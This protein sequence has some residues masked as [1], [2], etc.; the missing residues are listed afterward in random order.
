MHFQKLRFSP[1]FLVFKNGSTPHENEL[2]FPFWTLII[3][4]CSNANISTMKYSAPPHI[5]TVQTL[6]SFNVTW[7][8]HF[9]EQKFGLITQWILITL[10]THNFNWHYLFIPDLWAWETERITNRIYKRTQKKCFFLSKDSGTIVTIPGVRTRN[11]ISAI[12]VPTSLWSPW[13]HFSY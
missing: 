2:K 3:L 8:R 1:L 5:C 9:I 11:L 6:F 7:V 12:L 4:N 13:S 10:M